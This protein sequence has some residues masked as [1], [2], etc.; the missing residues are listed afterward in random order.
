[1]SENALSLK[2]DEFKTSFR[3]EYLK[4][5][6]VRDILAFLNV[7]DGT[8]DNAVYLNHHGIRDFYNDCKAELF[9]KKT[10]D[11]SDRIMAMD[12]DAL[13]DKRLA[14]QQKEA[15]FIRETLGK[16]LYSKR[17]EQ[18]GK[19]GASPVPIINIVN[20]TQDNNRA[21]QGRIIDMEEGGK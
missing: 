2:T 16:N 7:P 14:I 5:K 9:I 15:E 8:W 12:T 6:T 18:T 10:E 13:S 3:T 11:I 1:M 17:I 4:G 21:I 20:P 19:D